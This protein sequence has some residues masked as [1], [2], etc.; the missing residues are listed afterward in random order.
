M[1]PRLATSMLVSAL[2]RKADA[3]GGNAAVIVR[4]DAMSGAVLLLFADR[5]RITA[6]LER[7]PRPDGTSGWIAAGPADPGDPDQM[8]SYI[9]RRRHSDPD[10]WVVELD[11]I[12]VPAI[13]ELLNAV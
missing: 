3:E 5:G 9:E 7:G 2:L 10:L 12:G 11:G 6:T 4:G 1:M 8:G 13:E